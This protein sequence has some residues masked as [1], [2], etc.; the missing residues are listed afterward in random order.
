MLFSFFPR[1]CAGESIGGEVERSQQADVAPVDHPNCDGFFAKT[2]IYISS[3]TICRQG[4]E[5]SAKS[6]NCRRKIAKS[7]RRKKWD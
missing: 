7:E 4:I 3:A 6:I 1:P 5:S 2:L